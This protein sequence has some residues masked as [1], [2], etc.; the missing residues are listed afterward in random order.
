MTRVIGVVPAAGSGRRMGSAKAALLVRG[1]RLIDRAVG[2]LIEAGCPEVVAVVRSGLTVPG[3]HVVVNDDPD[4]GLRSSVRLGVA[5][6]TALGA[7]AIAVMLVDT[8]GVGAP[9]VRAV[10]AAWRPGRIAVATY[11]GRRGHPVVMEPE[12]WHRAVDL[13]APDE[14]A[15]ALLQADVE[16]VDEVSV[17]GDPVDLDTPAD[18]A[19]WCRRLDMMMR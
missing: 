14:G 6:G 7:D 17:E 18:L 9:A 19:Q 3:A 13:A 16:R 1:V 15:R 5:A 2:V 8:P 11:T 4:R 12:Q 10:V